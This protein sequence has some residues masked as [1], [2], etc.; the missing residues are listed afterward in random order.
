MAAAAFLANMAGILVTFVT[1]L[2]VD[3]AGALIWAFAVAG[4][5]SP[6]GTIACGLFIP[7]ISPVQFRS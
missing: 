3:R 4:L 1:G 7:D 5:V 6:P 2:V